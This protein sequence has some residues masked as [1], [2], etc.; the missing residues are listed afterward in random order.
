MRRCIYVFIY[1]ERKGVFGNMAY[2]LKLLL[3]IEIS[4][5]DLRTVLFWAITHRAVTIP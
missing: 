5:S 1:T 3:K 2:V 4:E